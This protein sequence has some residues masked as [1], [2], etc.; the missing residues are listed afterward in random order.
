MSKKK[1]VFLCG[2]RDFHAM[3]WYK[4]AKSLLKNN[5]TEVIILTDLIEG[6]GY[7]R[8]ITSNDYVEKLIILDKLL[9]RKQSK[10][11][12]IWRNILKLLVF[13]VQVFLI[14]RFAIKNENAVY[15]AH[16]MYYLF[17]AWAAKI[18]YIGTPQG[19]DILIKPDKSFLYKYFAVKSLRA[20]KAVTVD[21][22]KM[23]SRIKELSGI[24]AY[25]IQ[26]GIDIEALSPIINSSIN[27]I[28][29]KILSIRG[30][31]ALY[32]IKEILQARNN[33]LVNKE[34][35]L[36]FIYPFFESQYFSELKPLIKNHDFDLNRVERDVMYELILRSKLVLS[37]P[38]SDSSPRSVY[39]SIF[40]G[41][42]VAITYHPYYD[43]L[44]DCMKSRII[45]VN[46]NENNWFDHA[47]IK[48]EQII[49]SPYVPS[50]EAINLFDQ[51]KSF[52]LIEKL[53]FD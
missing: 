5:V 8:L 10:I 47:L 12:H 14:K 4:S 51:K 21:S 37:I 22:V 43:I 16:S 36:T 49:S 29:D 40:C 45:L 52:Q 25:I 3:D 53:L 13:P 35:P 15:H 33:S 39:E 19:S 7:K 6:E 48:A 26:N 46:L 41:A 34:L 42:A 27:Q 18:P 28:R 24:D 30:F 50:E 20:A 17:M 23:Q 31:T 32:R 9:F 38:I 1:L 2:S 11:A 44:P